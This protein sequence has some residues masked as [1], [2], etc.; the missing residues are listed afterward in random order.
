M[1][2]PNAHLGFAT[3]SGAEGGAPLAFRQYQQLTKETDQYDVEGIPGLPFILL[4]LFGETGSLLSELKKKKRDRNSY[5]GYRDSVVEELGDVLWY[6]SNAAHRAEIEL[7]SIAKKATDVLSKDEYKGIPCPNTFA[8]LQKAG[9]SFKGPHVDN[10]LQELLFVLAEQVGKI[11][12]SA[13][14]DS[15][16]NLNS[17]EDPLSEAFA[18]IIAIADKAELS[19]NH[20][21]IFNR[22]KILSRWPSN[23]EWGSLFDDDFDA[24]EQLPRMIKIVIKEK[25]MGGKKYVIQQCEGINI[26]NRLT[27]NRVEQDDYRFHDVFH[28]AYAAILGWSPVIRALFKVKR[29]SCPKIDENEDGARAILIEEGISTW[30]FNRGTKNKFFDGIDSLDYSL[31]KEVRAFVSGYEVE[32]RPLWQWEIAILE[33]FRVFRELRKHRQGIVIADLN[34]HTIDFERLQ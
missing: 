8:D 13:R 11:T 21:A 26:G 2:E 9:H 12:A 4:G 30:C 23:K 19:L 5:T 33:G 22:E 29:K 34:K 20:I 15:V 16:I 17:L 1:S 28:L 27:D 31:L 3:S 7:S 25:D 10:D 6:L 18:T 24:D 32:C 14:S